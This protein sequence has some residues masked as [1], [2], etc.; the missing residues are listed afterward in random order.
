MTDLTFQ[1]HV[2]NGTLV[3]ATVSSALFRYNSP[4]I[5]GRVYL[6]AQSEH[7]MRKTNMK[8]LYSMI[9]L[10]AWVTLSQAA[11]IV[12]IDAD[13][14][15]INLDAKKY[16]VDGEIVKVTLGQGNYE[17]KPINTKQGGNYISFHAWNG[18]TNCQEAAGCPADGVNTG[19]LLQYALVSPHI[20]K[21]NG[22]TVAEGQAKTLG[23]C[24]FDRKTPEHQFYTC[25]KKLV[26]PTMELGFN[27]RINST[28]RLNAD[29]E[30]GFGV[31]D[32]P[33]CL[34]D[35]LEGISLW[36]HKLGGATEVSANAYGLKGLTAT[37]KNVTTKQVVSIPLYGT[38]S[39]NCDA[40][41]LVHQAGDKVTIT[42]TG[43]TTN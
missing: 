5:G 7:I 42:I 23:N 33:A 28:F 36:V 31:A 30:V 22:R 18:L 35:N 2:L 38:G 8:T 40:A 9:T 14:M 27:G 3:T 25:G 29:S 12:P 41:G 6:L 32:C 1:Q 39:L 21:V 20:D 11:D 4:S 15:I 26:Y 10:I 43:N 34:W 19:W 13:T 17:V 24:Y 16:S 37:C